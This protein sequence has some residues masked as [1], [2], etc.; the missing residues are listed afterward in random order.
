M[1]DV[2]HK[3]LIE[4]ALFMSQSALG[5]NELVGATGIMSPGRVQEILRALVDDYNSRD[6]ALQLVEIGGKYMFALKEPYASRVSGLAVGPDLS[7]GALRILAYISKNPEVLQ[8]SLV[9]I[10]GSTTY[11]YIKELTDKEFI[12]TKKTGRSRKVSTTIK[13]KEYFNV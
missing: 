7:R 2:D 12:E 5:V 8:S 9:R 3:K 4:A 13:F 1:E 11:D 6:T 10:F